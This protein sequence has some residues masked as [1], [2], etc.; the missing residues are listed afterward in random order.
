MSSPWTSRSRTATVGPLEDLLVETL[1]I[2]EMSLVRTCLSLRAA[3]VQVQL[4]AHG[5]PLRG[6]GWV[7]PSPAVWD[8]R[9]GGADARVSPRAKPWSFTRLAR[10]DAGGAGRPEVGQSE[11]VVVG[12][13]DCRLATAAS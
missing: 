7:G 3:A 4:S 2:N 1:Q 6:S 10:R 12:R 13:R 5:R 11:E 8:G 9:P